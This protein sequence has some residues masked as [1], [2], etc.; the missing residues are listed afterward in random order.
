VPY[1]SHAT[2]R[3]GASRQRLL[4]LVAEL[5]ALGCATEIKPPQ[6]RLELTLSDEALAG[7]LNGHLSACLY[8]FADIV[9][10]HPEFRPAV[11]GGVPPR[12]TAP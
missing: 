8:R 11:L 7:L 4:Q 9:E 1:P 5:H 2:I 12:L 6:R 3:P 10:W